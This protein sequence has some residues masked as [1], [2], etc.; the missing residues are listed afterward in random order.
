MGRASRE[1]R[2]GEGRVRRC[3]RRQLCERVH[4]MREQ[5]S[6]RRTRP[7]ARRHR[8]AGP[9]GFVRIPQVGIGRKIYHDFEVESGYV[10]LMWMLLSNFL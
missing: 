3:H 1:G 8:E 7:D 9:S 4:C 10:L 5:E 6:A 2:G